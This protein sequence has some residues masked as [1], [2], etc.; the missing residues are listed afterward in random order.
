MKQV[1]PFW[2]TGVL[3][4]AALLVAAPIGATLLA[5]LTAGVPDLEMWRSVGLDYLV[6][7][8][9]LCGLVSVGALVIGAGAAMIV[10]LADFPGR[11]F[12]TIALALPFAIPAY[13]AAYAYADILG[14]FGPIASLVGPGRMP[15]IRS[16]PGAAFVLVLMTYPYVYLAVTASLG[17]RS[18][19]LMETARTLGATP[20]NAARRILLGAGRPALAGGLALALME[21]AAD[22][23][24]ADFFGAQT[25][26]VG[27]FRT[28]YGLGDLGAA[29]QLAAGLFLVALVLALLEEKTRRGQGAE[30]PRAHRSRARLKLSKRDA[31]FAIFACATPVI[32][33]FAIPA[34]VLAAKLDPDFSASALRGLSQ[35]LTNTALVAGIG[36]GAATLI[37]VTLAYAARRTRSGFGK[38]L[39]R[40][41]TMGY[42][43]PGAVIAIGILALTAG[44]ARATGAAV[45]G[46]VAILLYAYVARFLTAGYNAAAGGLQQISPQMDAAARNLG[47]TP[48]RILSAIHWPQTRGPILAGAAIVAIDIAKELPATL[49]LRPFNFETLSTRIYRLASDERLADAAPAALLLIAVGLIP[50][51]AL[52]RI[53]SSTER[54]QS[55]RALNA[56][57]A[58]S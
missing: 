1:N 23:G 40:V 5:S 26:S 2:K 13:V 55:A 39:L 52:S 58:T 9:V 15:E 8:I 38:I 54:R 35:S 48:S 57:L 34:G 10:T 3:A 6:G 16:L 42:A 25:L 51:L 29:T 49:L 11:R 43:I 17:G 19:A 28:W 12:F 14:P 47:A 44:I 7:T 30:N 20:A 41:A 24:V 27:I 37:A 18:G 32:L 21:T 50:T 36:A 33:G 53:S 56:G 45:A 46:G 4:A 31:G 22:Y